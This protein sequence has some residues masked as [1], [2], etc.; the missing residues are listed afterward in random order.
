MTDG[1]AHRWQVRLELWSLKDGHPQG[2]AQWR[3]SPP[4]AF[5]GWLELA[6]AL[7][8]SDPS[9]VDHPIATS[10]L[11]APPETVVGLDGSSDNQGK[12]E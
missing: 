6:R 10:R 7:E 8:L 5:S 9:Q 3:A 12:G 4:V 11:G 1:E 2:T